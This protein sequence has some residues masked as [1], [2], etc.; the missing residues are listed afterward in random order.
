MI[1][2]FLMIVIL[3]CAFGVGYEVASTRWKNE[4]VKRGLGDYFQTGDF[5]WVNPPKRD[6]P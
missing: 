6:E 2:T 3:A 4:A 5:F 1:E